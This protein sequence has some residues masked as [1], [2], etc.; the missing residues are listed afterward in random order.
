MMQNRINLKLITLIAEMID[1]KNHSEL[2]IVARKIVDLDGRCDSTNLTDAEIWEAALEIVRRQ[3]YEKVGQTG[4]LKLVGGGG[5]LPATLLAVG[6]AACV[7]LVARWLL[8]K[9]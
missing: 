5:S 3:Q 7:F 1:T 6:F 8:E 9:S 2:M 4:Y